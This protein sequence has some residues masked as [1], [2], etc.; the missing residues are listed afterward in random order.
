MTVTDRVLE[1]VEEWLA[2]GGRFYLVA[3]AN[4]KPGDIVERLRVYG[5]DAEVCGVWVSLM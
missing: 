5:M 1:R 3:V 4:N 2:P